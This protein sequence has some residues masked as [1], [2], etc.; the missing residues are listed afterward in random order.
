MRLQRQ[1][2][3]APEVEDA[4]ALLIRR[5]DAQHRQTQPAVRIN[6]DGTPADIWLQDGCI[7]RANGAAA[8]GRRIRSKMSGEARDNPG[9]DPA[10]DTSFDPDPDEDHNLDDQE[11][12]VVGRPFPVSV[13]ALALVYFTCALLVAGLP[14]LS[15]FLGK[16]ALLT[17]L[18]QPSL[19]PAAG[20]Q[21]V[22]PLA[23]VLMAL[24]L[25]AGLS[26]TVSLARAGIRH[27][28]SKGGR[29]ALQVRGLEAAA[30]MVPIGACLLLT[31]FAEPALR[32]AAAT[33]RE[34][35][36]PGPYIEAV[37]GARARPG[38]ATPAADG[39]LP[40]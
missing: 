5:A 13:A 4:P 10:F 16:A 28:W 17:A 18:V 25:G 27:F 24:L 7:E 1:H 8:F 9:L 35:H 22:P 14:P 31:V 15:G 26:T 37:L 12:P 30:V 20:G 19:A 29:F 34:L 2:R 39:T 23:W 11:L 3:A 21:G 32:Y 33:A 40:P 36:A 6:S 38:P